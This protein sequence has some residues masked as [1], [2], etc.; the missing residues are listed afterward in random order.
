MDNMDN[1]D[2][3]APQDLT[4]DERHSQMYNN[5]IQRPRTCKRNSK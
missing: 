3:T 1:I 5:I 4:R 2:N